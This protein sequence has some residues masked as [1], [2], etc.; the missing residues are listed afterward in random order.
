MTNRGLCIIRVFIT[1]IFYIMSSQSEYKINYL[2]YTRHSE[3][4]VNI[5]KINYLTGVK[6]F[7][8]SLTHTIV[9]PLDHFEDLPHSIPDFISR[10]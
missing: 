2:R 6:S 10:K 8:T 3:M 1:L 4:Y 9:R 5:V 7:F